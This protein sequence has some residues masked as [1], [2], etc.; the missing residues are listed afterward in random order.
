MTSATISTLYLKKRQNEADGSVFMD[1]FIRK[2]SGW[3]D[4]G[5]AATG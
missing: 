2:I 1:P 3:M 5:G 4:E